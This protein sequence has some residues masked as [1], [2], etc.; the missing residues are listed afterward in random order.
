MI[1]VKIVFMLLIIWIGLGNI[2][3]ATKLSNYRNPVD[4]DNLANSNNN[5]LS[6]T[7]SIPSGMTTFSCPGE[8][9][10]SGGFSPTRIN[11]L[12][13]LLDI[14]DGSLQSFAEIVSKAVPA[15]KKLL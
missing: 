14:D 4:K 1:K 8:N 5:N 6:N 3:I 13:N 2:N 7:L 15:N 9:I 11:A 10:L 12:L